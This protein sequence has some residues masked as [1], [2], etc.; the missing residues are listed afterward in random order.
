L[1]AIPEDE[2]ETVY[3]YIDDATERIYEYRNSAY[4]ILD[5]LKTDYNALE[6]DV[7]D[8]QKKIANGENVEFLK[9]V[10]TKLG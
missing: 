4:G 2:L 9:E 6:F 7:E 10:L 1:E 5:A 8:M 3:S